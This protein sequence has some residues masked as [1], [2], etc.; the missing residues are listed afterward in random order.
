MYVARL[1]SQALKHI[2]SA[3]YRNYTTRIVD[4]EGI[5]QEDGFIVGPKG[6]KLV[7]AFEPRQ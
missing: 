1:I 5:E 3:I 6:N 7:L 4:D 2:I